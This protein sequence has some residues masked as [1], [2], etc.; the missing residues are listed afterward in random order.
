MWEP[1]KSSPRLHSTYSLRRHTCE[2]MVPLLAALKF[3]LRGRV[4]PLQEGAKV[5]SQL[6][7]TCCSCCATCAVLV[8]QEMR[9]LH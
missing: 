8:P 9:E 7:R 1:W 2:K 5:I 3:R 6:F 4:M